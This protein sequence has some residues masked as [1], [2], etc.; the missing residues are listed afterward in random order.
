MPVGEVSFSVA[1]EF[2]VLWSPSLCWYSVQWQFCYH[3]ARNIML[4]IGHEARSRPR[5]WS[6]EGVAKFSLYALHANT[7]S[8]DPK[9][10]RR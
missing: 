8:S 1:C 10:T 5:Y 4:E 6:D 3:C 9:G 2:A 7:R